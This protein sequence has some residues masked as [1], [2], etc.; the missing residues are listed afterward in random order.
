[1]ILSV[2][3]I[4]CKDDDIELPFDLELSDSEIVVGYEDTNY[5]NIISGNGEYVFTLGDSIV[6]IRRNQNRIILTGLKTGNTELVIAD[7]KGKEAKIYVTVGEDVNAAAKA[8]F[9]LRFESTQDGVTSKIINSESDYLFYKDEGKIEIGAN[10]K[11]KS[12]LGWVDS[13]NWQYNFI[14]W[15]GDFSPGRKNGGVL[16]TVNQD[17]VLETI[18][19]TKIAV[20][21][22]ENDLVWVA[23]EIDNTMQI[24]GMI[25]Q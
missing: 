17:N 21:K 24:R 22:K 19:L 14:L 20:V 4:G 12:K 2:N 11:A 5:F 6:S 25:V 10:T 15:D 9:T 16:R 13:E 18:E 8:D 1:M 3:L 23:F 7:K